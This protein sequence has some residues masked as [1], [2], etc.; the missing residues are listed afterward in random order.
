MKAERKE[1]CTPCVQ[2]GTPMEECYGNKYFMAP[3]CSKPECPQFGLLQVGVLPAKIEV[4][5]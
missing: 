1:D 2:C 3:F 4:K 5:K